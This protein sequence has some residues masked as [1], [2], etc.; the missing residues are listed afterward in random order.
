MSIDL[1][2]FKEQFMHSII[3]SSKVFIV[4]HNEPDFD[5]IGS[6]IGIHAIAQAFNTEAY[7]IVNDD[8]L[9]LEPGVKKIIEENRCK[10]H[11]ITL[12]E[13][14]KLVDDNSLLI[15][16]DTNKDYLVSVKDD[17]DMF[18]DKIVIDHHEQDCHTI[19][20]KKSFINTE[21]SSACEIV[22]N[23]IISE[24]LKMEPE[25][26]S[27]LLAG[28]SLD[29]RRFK[30]NTSSKTHDIAEK[31]LNRGADSDYVNELF[32]EEFE[33]YCKIN[34]LIINGTVFKKYAEETLIPK[35]VSFTINREA[36]TTIYR[37]EEIAK[38]ADRMLKFDVDAS[39]VMGYNKDGNV[40]LSARSLKKPKA[41]FPLIG[42]I[43]AGTILQKLDENHCGGNAYSAGGTIPLTEGP[44]TSIF[45]IEDALMAI[46]ED[47]LNS[48]AIPTERRKVLKYER[49]K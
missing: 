19:E 31:L 7:I 40:T 43:E 39:F 29:T 20:A 41:S 8:A 10:Y 37:R 25:V 23:L 24:R 22:A 48:K 38:A 4:G 1:K 45:E 47:E 34:N 30:Q 3:D 12:E 35:Q 11:I 27:Y 46:V 13:A 42:Q 26:A 9:N 6:A 15:V 33:S 17:L 2:L 21:A 49:K 36:P 16:T 14:K 18:R 5:A 32:R 28:I 44:Y